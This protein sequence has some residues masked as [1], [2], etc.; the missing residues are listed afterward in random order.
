MPNIDVEF[1]RDAIRS[2][3]A[4]LIDIGKKNPLISFKHSAK[5]V[6][7]V[8]IVDTT[9]DALFESLDGE[10]RAVH[11]RTTPWNRPISGHRNFSWPWRPRG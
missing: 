10:G 5:G 2:L 6:T 1:L 3:R 7:Y 8:R 11:C 4:K 9:L